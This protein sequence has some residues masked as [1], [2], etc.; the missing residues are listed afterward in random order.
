[1][2]YV[3]N[4]V[5]L[6]VG[7]VDAE[8]RTSVL[9][10]EEWLR[11]HFKTSYVALTKI[12]PASL[13]VLVSQLNGLLARMPAEQRNQILARASALKSLDLR[14]VTGL[15]A[16]EGAVVAVAQ[17]ADWT[18][19]LAN[20]A[21]VIASLTTVGFGVANFIDQRKSSK[22]QKDLQERQQK[23]AED[24]MAQDLKERQARLDAAKAQTAT[25]TEQQ[26]T[27]AKQKELDASGYM[28]TPD[29]QVVPKP[30]NTALTVGAV[31]A[32]VAGAFLMSK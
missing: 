32:A 10:K 7:A 16:G 12:P 11:S 28:L 23:M 1:M 8:D 6:G 19:K 5:Y 14:S 2:A 24:Q 3:C 9:R 30:K 20:I 18:T 21:G 13:Q 15:G 29:G 31:G 26:A 27:A 17:T 25:L 22:E 4:P